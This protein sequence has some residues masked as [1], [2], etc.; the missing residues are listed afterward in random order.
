MTELTNCSPRN[1]VHVSMRGPRSR[2]GQSISGSPRAFAVRQARVRLHGLLNALTGSSVTRWAA[3]YEKL[4]ENQAVFEMLQAE[5]GKGF[6]M[7]VGPRW[8]KRPHALYH[9]ARLPPRLCW[10]NS[11]VVSQLPEVD[12]CAWV[13]MV[14]KT[15]SPNTSGVQGTCKRSCP[16]YYR[17]ASAGGPGTSGRRWATVCPMVVTVSAPTGSWH[18]SMPM[19]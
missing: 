12:G 16:D 9:I 13:S 7:S 18:K 6:A 5:R 2:Q 8:R 3:G 14:V 19:F 15:A 11:A 10:M 1:A 4:R 17:H